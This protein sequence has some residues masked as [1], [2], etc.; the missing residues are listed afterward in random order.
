MK[1][2][3]SFIEIRS[4]LRGG[5]RQH[6][7]SSYYEA[8]G[9]HARHP[10][11]REKRKW[12]LHHE[13]AG[14]CRQGYLRMHPHQDNNGR[15]GNVDDP[16]YHA[17][18]ATVLFLPASS[19]DRFSRRNR[20][21]RAQVSF[22]TVHICVASRKFAQTFQRRQRRWNV[23]ARHSTSVCNRVEPYANLCATVLIQPV[24]SCAPL[25]CDVW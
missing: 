13:V 4:V 14:G 2:L 24:A 23:F 3:S 12:S 21:M 15:A 10:Y 9:N 18:N 19:V 16:N 6:S 7:E 22:I 25:S 11:I 20:L 1:K 5:C 8:T 17:A